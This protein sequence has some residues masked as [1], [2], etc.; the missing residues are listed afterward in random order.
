MRPDPFCD[1]GDDGQE[2]DGCLPPAGRDAEP[3]QQGL[4]LCLP[5]GS[6]DTDQFTQSGPAADMPPD[7]LL[8]TIINTVTGMDGK[9]LAGL[10]DDQLIGVIAA[11]RRLESRA[12]WYL[13][14]AVGEFTARN[15][16][17]GCVEEFAADQLAHELHLTVTSAAAQMDYASTVT[18]RLPAT[19]AALHAGTI[20]PVHARIIEEETRILSGKDAAKADAVLAEA[21][22][23]LTFGKLRSTAHRLVLELDP[24]SA[25]R[26]KETARQDAHVRRFRE[27]SGNAGMVARELPPDEVLA[28]WQHVEQRA[29]D[30]RAADIPGT[31]QELRVQ[32]YLDL[33][34][35]RDSRCA[36][37]DPDAN[38]GRSTGPAHAADDPARTETPAPPRTETMAAAARVATADQA[39]APPAVRAAAAR[40]R[41]PDR[42]AGPSFAALVNITVPWAALTDQPGAPA[43][44]AGFGLVDAADAR[45]LA[46]A[47][48]RDPRTRWCVTALHP[49]GTAAAHGCAAGRHPP[50]GTER[51][52]R[53]P[54]T[55]P[56]TRHPPRGLDRPPAYQDDPDR[57]RH[58]RPRPRRTRLPAQPQAPAPG[59]G[60]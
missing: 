60:A 22:G 58:L 45:D 52:H 30:L 49:D 57:P 28:S 41:Q 19:Y 3:A 5:A 4:F 24:E 27:E 23:S 42:E 34:Q 46:A 1:P 20:H 47:A 18:S 33:L 17:E 39:T 43:D 50:P 6:L 37:A 29:L 56:T 15:T 40:G 25:E 31:L 14:A 9:G 7:P 21:A 53:H 59:Q 48:A 16:G 36:P 11:V 38:T 55:R 44:V 12:A 2:P 35:E 32:A 51:R 26:R 54:R 13:M 10:S 8:A